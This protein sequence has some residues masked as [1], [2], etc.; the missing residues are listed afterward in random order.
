MTIGFI[1]TRSFVAGFTRESHSWPSGHRQDL[2]KA[3]RGHHPP[4]PYAVSSYD[5][6]NIKAMLNSEHQLKLGWNS[7]CPPRC[8]HLQVWRKCLQ[9]SRSWDWNT[10]SKRK[11]Q[12]FPGGAVVES[13]PANAGD[14]GSSPG[15]GRSHVPRSGWAREPQLLS[16]H[17][18]SLCSAT[19]EAAIVRGPCTAMKNGP[20]LPQLEK[21][22]AEKRR[23]NTAIN[24]INK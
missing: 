13:L 1:G 22:L 20:R 12:G 17:V 23:P 6:G 24:K 10:Y 18:W 11:H 9:V 19:R 16:L 7:T 15:L 14:T 5:R 4:G 3:R 21:A 8:R 2:V